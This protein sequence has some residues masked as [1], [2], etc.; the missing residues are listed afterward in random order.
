MMQKIDITKEMLAQIDFVNTVSGGM[1]LFNIKANRGK[2]GYNMKITTPS[3]D[4][5]EIK[6]DVAN[7]RF[8][9]YYMIDV[10]EGEEKMPFFIANLPLLPDVD[11]K[12]ISARFE[13][14]NVHI[15]APF[16]DLGKGER[17]QIDLES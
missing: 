9:V 16:N 5:D 2:N 4:K 7:S 6:I 17:F 12:K 11:T 3:L 13:Q 15:H 1:A 10:L 14:G 8:K